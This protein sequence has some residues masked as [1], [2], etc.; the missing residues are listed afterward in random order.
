MG[1]KKQM[2]IEKLFLVSGNLFPAPY[3]EAKPPL[4]VHMPP[5]K[6]AKL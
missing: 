1:M 5:L 6:G 4:S 2:S 3:P